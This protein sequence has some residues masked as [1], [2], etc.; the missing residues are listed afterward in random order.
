MGDTLSCLAP[1]KAELGIKLTPCLGFSPAEMQAIAK[2]P[3]AWAANALNFTKAYNLDGFQFDEELR[4]SD[5]LSP[6]DVTAAEAG[7]DLLA[8]GLHKRNGTLTEYKGCVRNHLPYYLGQNC[9]AAVR[10]MP[11]LDRVVAAGTYWNN[12]VDGFEALLLDEVLSVVENPGDCGAHDCL[13]TG[14]ALWRS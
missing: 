12:T 13:L 6:T 4:L 8:E 2:H 11:H 5:G 14:K 1:M 9:S 10:L 7:W 3:A